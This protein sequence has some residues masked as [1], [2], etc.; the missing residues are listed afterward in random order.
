MIQSVWESTAVK[1]KNIHEQCAKGVENILRDAIFKKTI[2]NIT[3]VLISFSNF[4]K[5]L[6]PRFSKE[7]TNP[8]DSLHQKTTSEDNN[9]T[10]NFGT[11]HSHSNDSTTI[12]SNDNNNKK[13]IVS[14]T[15]NDD[16][17]N[18]KTLTNNFNDISN[19][20]RFNPFLS[21]ALYKGKTETFGS[22]KAN[23]ITT[24]NPLL[25]FKSTKIE[26]YPRKI[27]NEKSYEKFE[28][29]RD[30]LNGKITMKE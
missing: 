3:V 23:N 14:N 16:A 20:S 4:K 21:P 8:A 24:N 28:I 15:K 5:K 27:D 18:E 17:N 7:K 10:M 22:I 9:N 12:F 26:N 25:S 6:F 29:K 13:S 2:D 11:M 19:K 30:I 1:G